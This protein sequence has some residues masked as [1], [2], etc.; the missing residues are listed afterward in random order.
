MPNN[1]CQ[2]GANAQQS[3]E[4]DVTTSS[5]HNAKPLSWQEASNILDRHNRWRRGE[6][7]PMENP[8][9]LGNA[10]DIVLAELEIAKNYFSGGDLN[11][12]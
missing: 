7:I 3:N 8:T 4:T 6:N 12:R 5:S 1:K 11:F 2:A 10:I 9:I